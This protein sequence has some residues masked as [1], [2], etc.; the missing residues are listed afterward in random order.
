MNQKETQNRGQLTSRIKAKS[1]ELLGY[2]IT[3][4]EL[5]LMPYI[6]STMVNF[7]T[8]DP[9][10][11]N[12][13]EREILAKWREAGHIHGGASGLAIT[14]EFWLIINELLFLGYVDLTD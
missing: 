11:I 12:Q 9:N 4:V 6:Q 7:Q 13:E 1:L 14:K 5:R 10:K 2:E 8:L 3:Q